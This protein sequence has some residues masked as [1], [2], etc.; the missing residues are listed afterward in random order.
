MIS[1]PVK[2]EKPGTSIWRIL[3]AVGAIIL[4]VGYT[5]VHTNFVTGRSLLLAFPGWEVTYKNC[6]PN[7]LG[8][9]WVSDVTLMPFEGDE[10]DAFHF[11][12]LTVDVPMFQFYSSGLRKKFRNR[13]EA[14]K[15]IRLEFSGGRGTLVGPF[16]EELLV[17]GNASAAPFEAAGCMEDDAWI[18]EEFADMG[19]TAGPTSLTMIWHRS[20]NRL[21][22]EQT[23]HTPG[24]GRVDYREEQVMHDEFP[25][26]SLIETDQNELATG[27]WRIRDEGFVAARNAWC[28]RKDGISPAQFVDRHVATV[29]RVLAAIG[30][31]PRDETKVA[32]RRYA[33]KGGTLDLVVNYSPTIDA[34][35]YEDDD[36]GRWL[37]R[38]NG[39][40]VV[41][42]QSTRL[43]MRA[44]PER[45]FSDDFEE[46]TAFAAMQAEQARYDARR[47]ELAELAEQSKPGKIKSKVVPAPAA[48]STLHAE[49]LAEAE[50]LFA[51]EKEKPVASEHRI[52]DYS[53]LGAEV[54]QSFVVQLKGKK[55]MRVEVT[56]T[57]NGVVQV[58]RYQ[59]SGW[60]EYGLARSGF[61]YADRV[62]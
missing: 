9:A 45:P 11:D 16:S 51:Q 8:G 44:I 25:L 37:A 29:Q 27:E 7:P 21:V 36:W 46:M 57:E 19:L 52:V 33:E 31:E 35:I 47:A 49:T 22:K 17:F 38:T 58:R 60:L 10:E 30:M 3:G 54:G 14:I 61:E 32:Y 5:M 41:E 6:W 18:S 12:S 40:L 34:A 24:V 26:F 59:R 4:V 28:A 56:G 1:K 13:L 43:G 55:P 15:D 48:A 62:R 53:K 23:V 39:E 42:G 20:D 50:A 2:P